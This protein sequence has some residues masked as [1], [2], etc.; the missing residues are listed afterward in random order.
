MTARPVRESKFKALAGQTITLS[1]TTDENTVVTHPDVRVIKSFVDGVVYA[2]VPKGPDGATTAMPFSD[3][4]IYFGPPTQQAAHAD[5]VTTPTLI[6]NAALGLLANG[7]SVKDAISGETRLTLVLTPSGAQGQLRCFVN[8][9]RSDLPLFPIL[10]TRAGRTS[11]NEPFD[12]NVS[13]AMI[14]AQWRTAFENLLLRTLP[15]VQ[16]Q[17]QGQ[18][19]HKTEN[20]FDANRSLA[21]H[22]VDIVEQELVGLLDLADDDQW[23]DTKERYKNIFLHPI[24]IAYHSAVPVVGVAAA[25]AIVDEF[26]KQWLAP[27]FDMVK[28]ASVFRGFRG[29]N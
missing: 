3:A 16:R 13:S 4:M 5:P 26:N 24:A 1:I 22:L 27:T 20:R 28:V 2:L 23:Y 10:M 21:D 19:K 25:A 8:I 9:E 17:S 15:P 18:K 6:G 29:R 7:T 14:A 12:A 11:R